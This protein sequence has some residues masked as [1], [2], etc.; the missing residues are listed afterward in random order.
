M[1]LIGI[2]SRSRYEIVFWVLFYFV[3]LQYDSY[4]TKIYLKYSNNIISII[5]LKAKGKE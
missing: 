2:D 3:A 4:K 1:A 5:V